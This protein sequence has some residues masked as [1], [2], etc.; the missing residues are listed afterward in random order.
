MCV[1]VCV[2]RTEQFDTMLLFMINYFHW[3][4]A[5]RDKETYSSPVHM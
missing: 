2:D 4:F 5:K 1:C 3:F